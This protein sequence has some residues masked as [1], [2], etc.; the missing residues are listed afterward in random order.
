M[1]KY[2]FL[3]LLCV[4]F[5]FSQKELP[6]ISLKDINNESFNLK[7]AFHQILLKKIN[8]IFFLFGLRG[9]RLVLMSWTS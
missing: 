6:N 5:A 8:C 4:N 2:I 1:K 3:A 7:E 9:A